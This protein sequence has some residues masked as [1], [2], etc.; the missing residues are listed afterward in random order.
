M[1]ITFEVSPVQRAHRRLEDA[2]RETGAGARPLILLGG[3]V[4]AWGSN[5]PR[6]LP[7]RQHGLLAAVGAAFREHYPLVLTPDTVWLAIAQGFAAHVNTNAELLRGKF[8]RHE[9]RAELL[10]RRDEFVVGSRDNP[11]PEVFSSFSE[12]IA[13]HIGRQ[14]DL[15]VCDFSTTG[16]CERAASEI[17]LLDAMS[18]YFEYTLSSLCGIPAITLEG[19]AEDYRSIRRRVQALSEYELS[20]WTEALLPIVDQLI[21]ASEGRVDVAFWRSIFK[22]HEESGGPFITGW[23]NAFF[24]YLERNGALRVNRAVDAMEEQHVPS[25]V[26]VV[27]FTWI[28]LGQP[29]RM[30][31]LAGFMGISQ[32]EDTLALRPAIGWAVR[33]L[34]D[35]CEP[36]EPSARASRAGASGNDE[37]ARDE[38]Q[39]TRFSSSGLWLIAGRASLGSTRW[40]GFTDKVRELLDSV[41]RRTGILLACFHEPDDWRSKDPARLAFKRIFVG[42][43]VASC[44][45]PYQ[46]TVVTR[47]FAEAEEHLQRVPAFVW[48]HLSALVPGG[49][50]ETNEAHLFGLSGCSPSGE[51]DDHDDRV[52]LV[53]G[54]KGARAAGRPPELVEGERA[55]SWRWSDRWTI[56][57]VKVAELQ[58]PDCRSAVVD[59]SEAAEAE[60][61]AR[62]ETLGVSAASAAYHLIVPPG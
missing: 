32:D 40:Y 19:T 34:S 42:V 14:R 55:I 43:Q 22:R 51:R 54:E 25:G 6:C 8:V 45:Y 33:G 17:V 39:D 1:A 2:D 50:S 53:F 41:R 30:E 16:P 21:E 26:S 62:V 36:R 37:P 29:Y 57:G 58:P 46:D 3:P 48:R 20:W 47:A 7:V 52:L 18:G 38:S 23:I 60:R 24:P 15:V 61:S 59:M 13:G 28:H 31:F 11:W 9:G 4:E 12:Q 56:R 5:P 10:V 44:M 27:P 49:L 35:L